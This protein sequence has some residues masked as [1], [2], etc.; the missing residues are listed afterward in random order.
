MKKK[1]IAAE[2]A[3]RT[4]ERKKKAFGEVV[5]K[6]KVETWGDIFAVLDM[7]SAG[8]KE[9]AAFDRILT[10]MGMGYGPERIIEAMEMKRPPKKDGTGE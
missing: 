1:D 5:A 8:A 4:R 7:L 10:F 3:K 6:G 2:L 9:K